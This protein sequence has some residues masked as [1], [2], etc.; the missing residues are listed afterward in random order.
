MPF[1]VVPPFYSVWQDMLRRCNNPNFKQWKHYGGRG[2]TV[3][4]RWKNSYHA[5]Y[6]DMGP[7]PASHYSLDRIDNDLGYFPAN[8]QWATRKRQQ[9]N[10]TVTRKII[11]EGVEYVA[12]D[13]A[14]LS[15]LKTD[16]ILTRVER[17]YPFSTVV[18]PGRL[19]WDRGKVTPTHCINGHEYTPNN[20]R[21]YKNGARICIKCARV[22]A[23][24]KYWRGKE[25]CDN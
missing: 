5:F 20:T 10:Q 7:K 11:I 17:G 14:E 15:G 2:I 13:L 16:T 12:A 3:C 9:R 19:R 4:D 25:E 1:K 6:E 21:F 24:R 18:Y 22:G 8:C 23:K